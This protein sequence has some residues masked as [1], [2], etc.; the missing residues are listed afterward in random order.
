MSALF[1]GSLLPVSSYPFLP[2]LISLASYQS[3]F[4]GTSIY[5]AIIYLW[6]WM[7][8]LPIRLPAHQH[9][10]PSAQGSCSF[11]SSL[12]L[13]PCRHG[14]EGTPRAGRSQ[15][16]TQNNLDP[17]PKVHAKNPHGTQ[18]ATGIH[19]AS[20][21][22]RHEDAPKLEIFTCTHTK[23][24]GCEH[25]DCAHKHNIPCECT[26]QFVMAQKQKLTPSPHLAALQSKPQ[27]RHRHPHHS[28]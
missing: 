6:Y 15:K 10:Y 16:P 5:C 27:Q 11:K 13:F 17:H 2:F 18:I 25:Q 24:Y 1:K 3:H 23:I 22:A 28:Q 26:Q 12:L 7:A 4:C 9:K 19:R 20:C 14:A 8:W 21:E